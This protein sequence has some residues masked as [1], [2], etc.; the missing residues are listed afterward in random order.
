MLIGKSD[1]ELF[2]HPLDS[3]FWIDL[4][5][6]LWERSQGFKPGGKIFFRDMKFGQVNRFIVLLE[7]GKILV[8]VLNDN[9]FVYG[10]SVKALTR[11]SRSI[12]RI[13]WHLSIE[14][15]ERIIDMAFIGQ[16]MEDIEDACCCSE[17]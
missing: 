7:F 17:F 1:G 16:L 5:Y 4:S 2:L 13:S 10:K 15:F 3:L 9:L 11:I 14:G 8:E 12:S 6:G